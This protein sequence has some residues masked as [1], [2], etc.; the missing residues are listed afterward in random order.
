MARWIVLLG[1]LIV[2]AVVLARVL[3][4]S[5]LHQEAAGRAFLAENARKPGVVILDS[6][7][8]IETLRP[9]QGDKPRPQDMVMV[10]YKGWLVDGTE[11]D[12]SYARGEPAVFGVGDVIPGWSE[13]LQQM[14]PGGKYR[15]FIPSDLAYGPE[16]AG[17][18]IPPNAVLSFEVELLAVKPLP[19]P[20]ASPGAAAP[21]Q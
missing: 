3:Q 8:Q 14:Q 12:S 15:L 11:F 13:G 7:L 21:Q 18:V 6:G 20:S 16:G 2:G 4:P 9:G 19:L 1:A 17:G 10:H 5:S